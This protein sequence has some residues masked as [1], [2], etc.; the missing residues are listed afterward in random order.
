MRYKLVSTLFA[1]VLVTALVPASAFGTTSPD[2]RL[3]LSAV[4][5]Q[6]SQGSPTPIRLGET[7]AGQEVSPLEEQWYS[8]ATTAGT[9]AYLLK[10]SRTNDQAIDTVEL[11]DETGGDGDPVASFTSPVEQRYYLLKPNCTYK[12]KV[13]GVS[14]DSA[15][16]GTRVSRLSP[17]TFTILVSRVADA[18]IDLE[19]GGRTIES[20]Q[21]LAFGTSAN[22]QFDNPTPDTS[23]Q[24]HWF[25]F[26]TDADHAVYSLKLWS[27]TLGQQLSC[28]VYDG[29]SESADALISSFTTAD[30]AS[31][32]F[33]LKP[34][35][36]YTVCV[37]ASYTNKTSYPKYRLSAIKTVSKPQYAA[38]GSTDSTHPTSL[39]LGTTVSSQFDEPTAGAHEQWYEFKTTSQSRPYFITAK[40]KTANQTVTW[41][42]FERSGY[43]IAS[44]S[45]TTTATTACELAP[46]STYRICIT[47]NYN[48]NMG[49]PSYQLRVAEAKPGKVKHVKTSASK[50][51]ITV[52]FDAAKTATTYQIAYKKASA[53]KWKVVNTAA[54]RRVFSGLEPAMAYQVKVRSVFKVN[55]T[56]YTGRWSSVK[57]VRTKR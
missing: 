53:K 41:D 36:V 31:K 40:S 28:S 37:S 12:V 16:G 17:A 15:S 6:G 32:D 13:A 29:T 30:L 49:Y 23:N 57:S 20:A 43:R 14:I 27:D 2:A 45:T 54:L 1:A 5:T 50:R 24:K 18:P 35:R 34:N 21:A 19:P 7:L 33:L 47:S 39:A 10:V 11:Y 4:S 25:T 56:G 44:S 48:A 9:A 26:A 51:R 3:D 52:T 55:E 38:A 22:R 42:I 46:N 8:F